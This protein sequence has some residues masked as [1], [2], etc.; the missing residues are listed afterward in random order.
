MYTYIYI[1]RNTYAG[2]SRS[3]DQIYED[4]EEIILRRKYS[5]CPIR[6]RFWITAFQ[7]FSLDICVFF[8]KVVPS[9]SH[10]T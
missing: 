7:I 9:R 6:R 2:G 3:Y 8:G 1:Y 10:K 4:V 5:S